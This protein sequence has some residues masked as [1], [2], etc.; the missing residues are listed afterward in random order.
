MAPL[1]EYH[2]VEPHE[3]IAVGNSNVDELFEPVTDGGYR[4]AR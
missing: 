1:M 4:Y 3:H 2:R